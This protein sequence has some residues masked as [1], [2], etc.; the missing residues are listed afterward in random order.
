MTN[1]FKINIIII[2]DNIQTQEYITSIISSNFNNITI[3]GYADNTA[4]AI[5]LIK[6]ETPELILMDIELKD[7]QSFKIFDA[8]D[9]LNFE[10]IFITVHD[11]FIQ[12][13]IEHYAFSFIIKPF[14]SLKLVTPLERFINLKK[15]A[16]TDFKYKQLSNFLNTEDAVFLLQTGNEHVSIRVN[17]IIKCC[18]E[19]NYTQ[20][21][22]TKNRRYLASHSLKYYEALLTEKGFFKAHRSVLINIK[23]I[24]SI[25]KREAIVLNTNEKVH[26]SLRN[27][28]KLSDLISTLS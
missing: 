6:T 9:A 16:F 27:R 20:F 25:Y 5:K 4:T 14:D 23:A 8:L 12:K 1:D 17:D 19:K 28:T 15:R 26:V 10:V 24:K 11:N 2:E 18:A 3:K 22:L 21:Y 7:G 13:A